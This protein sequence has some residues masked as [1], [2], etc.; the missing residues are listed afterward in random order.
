MWDNSK[1]DPEKIYFLDY[2]L[3]K[4]NIESPF[5]FDTNSVTGYEYGFNFDMGFN[6]GEKTIKADF[7]L[8]V[9]TKSKRIKKQTEPLFAEGNFHLS[10]IFHVENLDEL[11]HVK[12]DDSID[13]NPALANAI[14]AIT[15][16][17][18]RGILMNRVQGT[19]LCN[20]ILPVVSPDKL[21]KVQE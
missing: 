20:F 2:K 4:G 18:S 15:F 1:F 9:K 3:L 19:A 6:F 11:S 14:A 12:E 5:E 13:L 21:L 16:S 8:N 7:G 17:T 10:F